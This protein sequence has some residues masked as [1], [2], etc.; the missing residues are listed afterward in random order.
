MLKTLATQEY[1]GN[2]Q[3]IIEQDEQVEPHTVGLELIEEQSRSSRS[4]SSLGVTTRAA[5]NAASSGES[6]LPELVLKPLKSKTSL[7]P[8][9]SS[10][11]SQN[12]QTKNFERL[13]SLGARLIS[14]DISSL[15]GSFSYCGS[16]DGDDSGKQS[17]MLT[18]KKIEK[19]GTEEIAELQ[20]PKVTPIHVSQSDIV[21]FN[22]NSAS[23]CYTPQKS[24]YS[25]AYSK[26]LTKKQTMRKLQ[27]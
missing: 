21:Q 10:E 11:L 3:S 6:P 22:S 13:E 24:N 20:L 18:E 26:K 4:E 15:S 9:I 5:Q 14:D 16:D 12:T 8:R 27:N 7:G 2:L 17:V 23:L 1:I 19:Q 25:K